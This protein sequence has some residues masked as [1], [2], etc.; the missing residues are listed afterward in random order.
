[1]RPLVLLSLLLFASVLAVPVGAAA[2]GQ[3]PLREAEILK[4]L[5]GGTSNQRLATMVR[6]SGVNFSLTAESEER[7][8]TL[9]ADDALIAAIRV[10][11][12]ERKSSA[13]EAPKPALAEVEILKGL[14][15]GIS[16]K[17]LAALVGRYGVDFSLS[18]ESEERLRTLGADDELIAAIRKAKPTRKAPAAGETKVNSKDGLTYVWIPPGTFQMGCSPG[19]S[20]CSGN[21]KP[22]HKVTI[23]K[24]FWMG[25]TEVTQ[26]AYPRV[27]GMNP[28][29]FRGERLPVDT[30]TWQDAS[31]YCTAVGMRLP[32][33]EEWEYAARAGTTAPRYGDLDAVAWYSDNGGLQTH[34]VRSK[35]PNAWGLYDM[36]GNVDEWTA[37]WLDEDLYSQSPTQDPQ[38]V[39]SE[40][41]RAARGG[42]WSA[43]PM[44]VRVSHR[45][46]GGRGYITDFSGFR[47]AGEVP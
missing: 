3:K 37:D 29:H 17:R 47:C 4:E 40:Q 39:S 14:A 19:D 8:R 33:E 45:F 28:S 38:R 13:A 5:A 7:L 42:S 46:K 32:T 6:E 21:E 24:G 44:G 27:M 25:Q 1:M 9:G 15:G 36:L 26:A 18:P 30:V 41:Y 22:A 23:T 34:E 10:A 20:E 12:A 11:A 16:S 31:T 43:V 35:Q 2:Q